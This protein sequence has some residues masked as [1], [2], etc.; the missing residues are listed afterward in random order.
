[1]VTATAC[2][3]HPN[4]RPGID[5][6]L[7]AVVKT[8]ASPASTCFGV[9]TRSTLSWEV[10]RMFNRLVPVESSVNQLDLWQ[11]RAVEDPVQKLCNQTFRTLHLGIKCLV[12]VSTAN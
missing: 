2:L 1:M 8:L 5:P 9:L 10:S 7:A 12:L 11:I 3:I 6:R 4:P